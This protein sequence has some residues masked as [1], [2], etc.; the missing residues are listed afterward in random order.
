MIKSMDKIHSI[1]IKPV[2]KQA[3]VKVDSIELIKD[4]G[5]AGDAYGG[6]GNRQLTLL[7]QD[8]R[9]ALEK[10]KELGFCIKK[11]IPNITLSGSSLQLKKGGKYALGDAEILI[12]DISKKCYDGCPLKDIEKRICSLPKTARFASIEKTGLIRVGDPVHSVNS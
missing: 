9:D 10:D 7:G 1:H 3:A 12:S 5:P 11:F 6:P 8:E 2:K 4:F